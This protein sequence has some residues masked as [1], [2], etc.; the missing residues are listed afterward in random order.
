MSAQKTT[1]ASCDGFGGAEPRV[2]TAHAE[3][4]V[5]AVLRPPPARLS[6]GCTSGRRRYSTRF[7]RGAARRM[8]GRRRRADRVGLAGRT[9]PADRA[10]RRGR[11]GRA[12]RRRRRLGFLW[13]AV[14]AHKDQLRGAPAGFRV[15]SRRAQPVGGGGGG[16]GGGGGQ[17]ADLMP[18]GLRRA[19]IV[20]TT[21][22]YIVS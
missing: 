21:P 7:R 19:T 10:G 4:H 16:A 13:A 14:L 2:G 11:A 9:V 15:A 12:R 18:G 5:L 1:D 6:L 20:C 3:R 17:L 8:A 22:R